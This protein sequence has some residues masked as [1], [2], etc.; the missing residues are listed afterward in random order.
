MQIQTFVFNHFGQ[1]TYLVIDE[2]TKECVVIDPGCFFD[3][4]KQKLISYI[5]T[6]KYIL[7]KIV[8]THC[9]LD[10]AFGARSIA[11]AFPNIGIYAHKNESVFIDDAINQSLRFGITMEQPPKITNYVSDGDIVEIGSHKFFAIHV[12][13][14]SPGSICYYNAEHKVIFCGDVLFAGSIGR[15]DLPGGNHEQLIEGITK[16][17]MILPDDV[18]VYSGHGPTTSI[19]VERDTNPYF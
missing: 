15:S 13:G 9:H 19:L 18:T 10:H 3:E 8:F 7:T 17:L 4:E 12:P 14:H 16:K 2:Q 11:N 1:N 6:N 5:Q